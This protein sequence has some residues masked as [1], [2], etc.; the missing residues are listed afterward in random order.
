MRR[1]LGFALLFILS[2]VTANGR[3][4]L[5]DVLPEFAMFGRETFSYPAEYAK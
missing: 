4:E 3:E 5:A 1:I 2:S